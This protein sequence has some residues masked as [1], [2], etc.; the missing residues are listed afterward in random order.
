M[1]VCHDHHNL[2]RRSIHLD[3][4]WATSNGWMVYSDQEPTA[5]L[6]KVFD[7]WT[8]LDNEGG[9]FMPSPNL[10]EVIRT[11]RSTR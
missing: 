8:Y 6:L 4:H 2:K 9:Y 5:V 10:E 7:K 3:V 1:A 11:L